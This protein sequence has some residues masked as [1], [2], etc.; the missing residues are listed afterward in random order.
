MQHST[1]LNLPQVL[2]VVLLYV[3]SVESSSVNQLNLPALKLDLGADGVS[4]RMGN[5]RDHHFVLPDYLVDECGLADVGPADEADLYS[6]F[7]AYVL[8][9]CPSSIGEA[10]LR[11]H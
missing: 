5:V 1:Y 3:G 6:T 9:F 2:L 8:D 7:H 11:L 10:F 4:S